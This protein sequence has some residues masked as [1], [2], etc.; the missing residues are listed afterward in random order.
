VVAISR[1]FL[2][3]EWMHNNRS[4]S[5]DR[6]VPL[7]DGLHHRGV[8]RATARHRLAGRPH[9]AAA[10]GGHSSA[11]GVDMRRHQCTPRENLAARAAEMGFEFVRIDDE[12]YWDERAYYSFSLKQIERDLEDPTAELAAMCLEFVARAVADDEILT[13]LAIP[14]HAWPL[15]AESWKRKDQTLYGRFDFAYDG[16]GPAKLLEYNADTPTSLFEASVFQWHWLED[17]L[18]DGKVPRGADQFNSLHE[19]LIERLRLLTKAYWLTPRL[20]LACVKDSIEDRG[21][22]AYLDDCAQQAGMKTNSIAITDIGSTASG[23]F[24]DLSNESINLLFKLYPWEWMF[25]EPFSQKKGMT[26][27]RFIEPP[28]KAVLSNKG[29]LPYLWQMAPEHPNLL[30][31]YFDDDPEKEKLNRRYAKKPLYS[32]EGSN[33]VLLDGK[34]VIDTSLSGPYGHEGYV[35]QALATLP[36]FDGN[37]PVIGSWVIGEGAHGIGIREDTSPITKDT[38]RFIPHI[39][40]N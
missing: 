23:A 32:R 21:L 13:R 36:N 30:P 25:A 15:I 7:A 10:L 29:I 20:H 5:A 2:L 34:D 6:R 18:A 24:V 28:W 14:E 35:L 4:R 3:R 9:L 39:I 22:I 17:M 38:S 11:A 26:T 19:A 12:I 16:K 8:G 1:R 33:I 31:A 40:L 27:T 37:Y